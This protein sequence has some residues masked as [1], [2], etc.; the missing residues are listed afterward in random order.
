MIAMTRNAACIW[1]RG[2]C[3]LLLFLSMLRDALVLRR[4]SGEQVVWRT[5]KECEDKACT[6]TQRL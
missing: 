4:G 2:H 1:C 3:P 6:F 5:I